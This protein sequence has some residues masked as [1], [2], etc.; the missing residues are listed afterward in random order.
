MGFESL[1]GYFCNKPDHRFD[2]VPFGSYVYQTDNAD[3]CDKVYAH[4]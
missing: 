4:M 3:N 2:P 1:F